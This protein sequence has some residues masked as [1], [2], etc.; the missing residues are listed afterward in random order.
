MIFKELVECVLFEKKKKKRKKKKSLVYIRPAGLWGSY[1]PHYGL[2]GWG[3]GG[4]GDG[5]GDTGGGY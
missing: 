2:T 1:W 4:S 5:G 3:D